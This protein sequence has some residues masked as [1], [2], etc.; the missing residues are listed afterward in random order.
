MLKAGALRIKQTYHPCGQLDIT[1]APFRGSTRTASN[2]PKDSAVNDDES[3][4]NIYLCGE[5]QR[6]IPWEDGWLRVPA[7]TEFSRKTALRVRDAATILEQVTKGVSL[8]VT[9]TVPCSLAYQ[10]LVY[11]AASGYI[12][13]RL[14]RF[15]RD[16]VLQGLFVYVW[17]LQKRGAPHIHLIVRVPTAAYCKAFYSDIRKQWREILLDASDKSYCDLFAADS[18]GT[19]RADPDLPVVNIKKI[20][21]SAARYVSKYVSKTK[22]KTGLHW[23]WS[24]GRWS[25]I[26]YPL[27]ELVRQQTEKVEFWTRDGDHCSEVRL[28]I[29]QVKALTGI[30]TFEYPACAEFGIVKIT[31]YCNREIADVIMATVVNRCN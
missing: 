28:V 11:S 27:L 26:S 24:P 20:R 29:E 22:S 31:S 23:G 8:F 19:W 6:T 15:L 25:S 9:L 16:R 21:I 2:I 3:A 14:T 12:A 17:E 10:R 13:N 18:G 1:I 30:T 5:S 7:P 4:P